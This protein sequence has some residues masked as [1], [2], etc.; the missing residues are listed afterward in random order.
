MYA[1]FQQL[2]HRIIRKRHGSSPVVPPRTRERNHD[3]VV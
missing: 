2:A 1:S 3:P